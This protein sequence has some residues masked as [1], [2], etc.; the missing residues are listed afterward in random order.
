[1]CNPDDVISECGCIHLGTKPGL[2]GVDA[3]RI[4][5]AS[6]GLTKCSDDRGSGCFI[7]RISSSAAGLYI[8]ENGIVEGITSDPVEYHGSFVNRFDIVNRLSYEIYSDF[9]S[10]SLGTLNVCC[11]HGIIDECSG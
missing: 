6:D 11:K 10:C 9:K 4:T 5:R 3:C 1:M 7:Y 8:E 2:V